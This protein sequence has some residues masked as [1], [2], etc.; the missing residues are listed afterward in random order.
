MHHQARTVLGI[1]S[2]TDQVSQRHYVSEFPVELPG[3]PVHDITSTCALRRI[4]GE[5]G[6][7]V[8]TQSDARKLLRAAVMRIA[9]ERV[10]S[11]D[12]LHKHLKA[13]I[14]WL[15]AVGR[16]AGFRSCKLIAD[17]HRRRRHDTG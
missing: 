12:Q 17:L 11:L 7:P 6:L 5:A 9:T 3:T 13:I 8:L 16:L 4:H 15:Q 14:G 1:T 2:S 10:K